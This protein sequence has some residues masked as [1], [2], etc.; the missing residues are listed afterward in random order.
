MYL[1]LFCANRLAEIKA[2]IEAEQELITAES[3]EST[4]GDNTSSATEDPAVVGAER[5]G[6]TTNETAEIGSGSA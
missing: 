2:A 1:T 3:E 4:Q 6:S 5:G